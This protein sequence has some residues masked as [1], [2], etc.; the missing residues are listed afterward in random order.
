ML[1]MKKLLIFFV[2]V[3][4]LTNNSFA[5]R[6][7]AD[8]QFLVIHLRPTSLFFSSTPRLGIAFELQSSR[9]RAYGIDIGYGTGY[10]MNGVFS[11]EPFDVGYR[12][13]EMR[14]E[15]K[16]FFNYN[17]RGYWAVETFFTKY[18]TPKSQSYI[19]NYQN[20][21]E[22]VSYET[23]EYSKLKIGLHPKLGM[24]FKLFDIIE[25][26]G[27]L[28]IGGVYRNSDFENVFESENEYIPEERILQ[29]E[30]IARNDLA[31]HVTA[32]IK[33]GAIIGKKKDKAESRKR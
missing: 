5:Q 1:S 30:V 33:I 29:T 3:F 20:L 6:K 31:F 18:E 10:I 28:G 15:V 23:A 4:L 12:F 32:G 24:K 25:L 8:D 2:L 19:V 13:F 21:G 14:P 16:F 11:G 9:S 22:D 27:F 7:K 17:Q 26:D